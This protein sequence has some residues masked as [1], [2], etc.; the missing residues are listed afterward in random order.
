LLADAHLSQYFYRK[1][2]STSRVLWR[3]RG[4]D[5]KETRRVLIP[6]QHL[7]CVKSCRIAVL[8]WTFY[9]TPESLDQVKKGYTTLKKGLG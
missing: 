5:S 1:G 9:P 3:V 4:I 8:T 7:D 2:I 6:R